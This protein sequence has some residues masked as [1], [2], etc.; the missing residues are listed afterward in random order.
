MKVEILEITDTIIETE[1]FGNIKRNAFDRWVDNNGKRTWETNTNVNG[2]HVQHEGILSWEGYYESAWFPN[3]LYE[4]LQH[5]SG[6]NPLQPILKQ[7]T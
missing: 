6:Y 2:E 1:L 5:I 3:D 4:Y 7:K